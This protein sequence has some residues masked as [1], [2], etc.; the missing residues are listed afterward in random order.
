[1][2]ESQ[3]SKLLVASSILVSRSKTYGTT[4]SAS[5]ARR[6]C[7]LC[8]ATHLF[9]FGLGDPLTANTLVIARVLPPSVLERYIFL[10]VAAGF[11]RIDGCNDVCRH[12]FHHGPL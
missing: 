9:R 5:P 8:L 10:C 3:L 7:K 6:R 1:M 2:V 4:K 11:C 12:Q